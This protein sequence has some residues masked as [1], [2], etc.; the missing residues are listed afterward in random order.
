MTKQQKANFYTAVADAFC[1]TPGK[2]EQLRREAR[3]RRL[4]DGSF[5]PVF[6]F[7]AVTDVHINAERPVCAERLRDMFATAYACS[8]A[9]KH[10]PTL[11]AVIF[12]GD[13]TDWGAQEQYDILN[14]VLRES[15]R[16]ETKVIT[17][18]G[19]H[20]YGGTG[21]EG[22]RK[23]LDDRLDKHEVVDGYHFIGLSPMPNDTWHTPKQLIWLQKELRK[24]KK[25]DPNKPIFTFQ[26]GHIWKSVY[27]SRSWYTQASAYLH[28]VFA[29]YPQVINFSGHSH[30]PINHPLTVWQ[31]RYT[32]FGA[33]TLNYFEME[34]DI[35]DNTVPAGSENA[36]QYFIVEIDKDNRVRVLP[37]NILTH[38]FFRTLPD[39]AQ[40]LIYFVENPA[41]RKTYPYTCARKKTDSA[42]RFS[43]Q[44]EA[45]VENVTN[46]SV[47]VRFDQA[48]AEVCVYGY[49]LMLSAA[50][51]PKKTIQR[52]E[53]Y[54]E[55]YFEPMPKT[56]SCTF[57]GLQP[58]TAYQVRIYP[59]NVW[60]KAGA[61]LSV[62]FKTKV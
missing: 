28:P 57:D 16:P 48:Q 45:V 19:N 55:Y 30:G 27:V 60:R 33:G 39:S 54:S 21:V 2:Q 7:A 38:D 14:D 24:A 5:T 15:V 53:I 1:R 18:M 43:Q 49:R 44:A 47:A 50:V 6:R 62:S 20:D 17:V 61:P 29:R 46:D 31:S 36:A 37:Y 34:R 42:P 40:Q 32:S 41:D 51:A 13:N 11:D 25:D 3:V 56:L 23:N 4:I 10:H 58:D 12:S 59:L 8:A 9:D 26:H 22:Y 52:K 35:G